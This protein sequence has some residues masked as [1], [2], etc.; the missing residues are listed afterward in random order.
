[1]VQI[2]PQQANQNQFDQGVGYDRL[3]RGKSSF[4]AQRTGQQ[5]QQQRQAHKQNDPADA[6]QDR[7]NPRDRQPDVGDLQEYRAM[8]RLHFNSS[9]FFSKNSKTKQPAILHQTTV[10]R[11]LHCLSV[12]EQ[13]FEADFLMKFNNNLTKPIA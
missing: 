5:A 12:I 1:V 8:F 6:V 4:T 2:R 13:P 10:M 7:N 9:L 3:I 11:N